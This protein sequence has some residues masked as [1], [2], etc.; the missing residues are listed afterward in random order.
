M[1]MPVSL[2]AAAIALVVSCAPMLAQSA[3]TTI[4]IINIQDAITRTQEGQKLIKALQDRYEP[5]SKELESMQKEIGDLRAKLN[6]GANT[7]SE[8]AKRDLVRQIQQ[9]ERDG[10]RAV[11]D[12]RGEFNQEQ[13][14]IFNEIGGK[15]MAVIDTFAK[16]KGYSIVLDISSPQS[17][18]LYAVNEVN[19]TN[20]VISA[21]DAGGGAAAG[22]D[23]AAGKPAP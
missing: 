17:P 5:K 20:D 23:G 1:K 12:A 8:E 2:R 22:G 10:Q 7:M 21:Y 15:L 3:G 11:E 16:E 13:Q 4:A 19:I 6:Q 9:K 18:V 14:T